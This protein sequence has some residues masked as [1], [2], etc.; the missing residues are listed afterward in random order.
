[1]ENLTVTEA[2][3][4]P[5]LGG[6]VFADC[7]EEFDAQGYIIFENVIDKDALQAVRDALEPHHQENIRGRNNFE[8]AQTNRVY[9]LMGKGKIFCEL[10][11]HPLALGF[12]E[13]EFGRSVWLSAFLSINLHPGETVQPWHQDDGHCHLPRPRPP[14][15]L[16]AFWPI[17]DMTDENGAT[18]IIPQS[19]LWSE[20]EAAQ[21][22]FGD[23]LPSTTETQAQSIKAVIPAGS[24]MLLKG[25][26][27]HRG[28][29][30]NST[31]PRLLLTPQYT[32]GWVR[33]LENMVLSVP[34]EKAR[35]MSERARELIGYS[36]HPPFM[37]YV[38]G[39]H[40]EKAL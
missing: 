15:Q 38:D 18:E 2:Q 13:K 16:S 29:A 4:E 23:E 39:V 37:G 8:G 33:Q 35:D 19:H 30:N 5:F 1:M 20:K 32:P 31:A 9:A 3:I 25:T 24:L 28:G 21:F 22:N 40:P 36:I 6:R 11:T 10:A 12:A 14:L 17:D 27:L 34:P 7:C 26:L